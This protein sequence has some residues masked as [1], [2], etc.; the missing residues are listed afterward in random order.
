VARSKNDAIRLRE[1]AREIGRR[2][3]GAPV[4]PAA[5]DPEESIAWV[6]AGDEV[7]VH[8]RSVRA[9]IEGGALLLTVELESDQTG[10]RVLTVPF[11]LAGA[12]AVA[13]SV[14][15]DPGLAARWGHILQD[16]LWSALRGATGP[17][18]SLSIDP[19]RGVLRIS[20]AR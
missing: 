2:L 16:A 11:V 8:P 5:P 17:S 12:S 1:L 14:H 19:K 9:R 20:S 4:G 13:G 6:D 7:A 3:A 18:A 10:R 15:G